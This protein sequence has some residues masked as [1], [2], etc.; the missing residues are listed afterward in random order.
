[1]PSLWRFEWESL[2][3]ERMK[4]ELQILRTF[5]ALTSWLS[6]Y[7]TNIH[8]PDDHSHLPS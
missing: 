4:I 8:T 1:M 2:E 3:V 7:L 6:E 5:P